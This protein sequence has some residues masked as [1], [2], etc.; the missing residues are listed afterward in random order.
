MDFILDQ[1]SDT[2]TPMHYHIREVIFVTYNKMKKAKTEA[3]FHILMKRSL[4][5]LER[6]MY[7]ILFNTYQSY[8]HC[9]RRNGWA[10]SFTSWMKEVAAPAGVYDLLDNLSFKDF[11][12]KP[13]HLKSRRERWKYQNS[14]QPVRGL[15]M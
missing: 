14:K 6:Y 9:E 15:F 7:L 3:E 10:R 8:L 11:E 1:C 5:Y 12:P 13:S 4:D 2:M